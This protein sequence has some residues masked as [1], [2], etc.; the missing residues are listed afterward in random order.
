MNG[1]DPDREALLQPE[2]QDTTEDAGQSSYFDPV[3]LGCL[4]VQHLSRYLLVNL[5]LCRPLTATVLGVTEQQSLPFT[6]IS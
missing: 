2:A 6:F 3:G 1:T 5:E 4:L